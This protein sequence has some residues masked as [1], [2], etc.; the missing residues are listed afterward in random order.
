MAFTS[1]SGSRSCTKTLLEIATV[2][3][4]S[5]IRVLPVLRVVHD[6]FTLYVRVESVVGDHA[7]CAKVAR[8]LAI[9]TVKDWALW[10]NLGCL[11]SNSLSTRLIDNVCVVLDDICLF[12]GQ[13]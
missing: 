3:C 5:D 8:E 7:S 1:R 4:S 11:S 6:T 12:K 2:F 9:E 10:N 13:G